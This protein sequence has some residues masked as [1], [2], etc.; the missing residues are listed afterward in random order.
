V[1]ARRQ[2]Y[3]A[4]QVVTLPLSAL[5]LDAGTQMRDRLDLEAVRDYAQALRDGAELPPIDAVSDGESHWPTDGF[6]RVE[7]HG[8]AGRETVQVRITPGTLD[9][10]MDAAAAANREHGVRR[11]K[12]TARNAVRSMLSRHADWSDRKIASHCGVSNS[13]VSTHR[14]QVCDSHTS[15]GDTPFTRTGRDGKQ[16]PARQVITVMTSDEGE[17]G[18]EPQTN[19]YH[20]ADEHADP[21]FEDDPPGSYAEEP[22]AEPAPAEP[23]VVARDEA[24]VPLPP[25]ALPAFA[26]MSEL[27]QALRAI[28]GLRREVERLGKSPVG[29][30]LHWQS[31]QAHLTNARNGLHQSRPAHVCPYCKVGKPLCR[32][33]RGS[34]WVTATVFKAAPKE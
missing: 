16:Y 32:V 15:D 10:A 5:T 7:A 14:K 8:D 21:P 26:Q 4:G 11:N 1:K 2:Q 13:T 28:D 22:P 9:D 17:P 20:A 30:H 25:P 34:G 33:C 19:G 27:G 23:K 29:F 31:V 3:K 6:H 18:A 24:G 12:E